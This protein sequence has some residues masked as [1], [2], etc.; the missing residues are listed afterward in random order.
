MS[1]DSDLRNIPT[2]SPA[3]LI[4]SAAG[5]LIN[6]PA[7]RDLLAPV[8]RAPGGVTVDLSKVTYLS[9]EAVVPL[10]ALA[11][12]CAAEHRPLRVLG[13]DPVR[14]KLTLLG[15]AAVV[16]LDPATVP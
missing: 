11:G 13:S 9:M 8:L 5:D 2:A 1:T 7:A 15:L 3:P 4:V 6:G 16:P 12:R 10:L 14:R